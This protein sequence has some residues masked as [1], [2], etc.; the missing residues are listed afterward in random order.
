MKWMWLFLCLPILFFGQKKKAEKVD[1]TAYFIQL[2]T[3]NKK[4]D[5]Y[6]SSLAFSQKAFNYAKAH[7][8]TKGKGDALFTLG[9]TYFDLKKMSDAIELSPKALIT[10]AS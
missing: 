10:T 6:K 3:F 9:T 2:A 7:N 4:T 8:D 1:S 5:N